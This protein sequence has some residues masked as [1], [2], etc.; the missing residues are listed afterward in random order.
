MNWVYMPSKTGSFNS[1]VKNNI[2]QLQF[3]IVEHK[4]NK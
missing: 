2:A 3:D 1:D 4:I